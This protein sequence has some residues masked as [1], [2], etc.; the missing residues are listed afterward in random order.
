[1]AA[2][3]A[4]GSVA[5]VV[6]LG[7]ARP[8][9]PDELRARRL[10]VVD[11]AGTPALQLALDPAGNPTITLLHKAGRADIAL[12]LTTEGAS[13]LVF[14]GGTA[15]IT[16]AGLRLA[17]P[18]G[19]TRATLETADDGTTALVLFDH[20]ERPAARVQVAREGPSAIEAFDR[21]GARVVTI[22]EQEGGAR[23]ALSGLRGHAELGIVADGSSR[24]SIQQ[25]GKSRA[26]LSAVSDGPVQLSLNDRNGRTRA[27]ITVQPGG[28]TEI[29]PASRPRGIEQ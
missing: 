17:D 3:I 9:V 29:E 12:K 2:G 5:L 21:T 19:R 13:S 25:D 22:G 26:G 1:M 4:L 16:P 7:A 6:L 8:K 14:L 18:A 11:Q 23:I 15:A 24:L 20:S 27:S 28:L 10:I